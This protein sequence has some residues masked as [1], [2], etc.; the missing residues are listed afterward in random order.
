MVVSPD[1]TDI[2]IRVRD[3][4]PGVPEEDRER[5]FGRFVQL[6]TARR[7]NGAGLGLPIARW[8]AEAHGGTVVLEDTGAGGSTFRVTLPL[9]EMSR[10]E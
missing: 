10:K 2:A 4:G 6:D 8:I 5:I 9:D 7:G 1:G 3:E